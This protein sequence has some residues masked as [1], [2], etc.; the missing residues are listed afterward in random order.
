MTVLAVLTIKLCLLTNL[1]WTCA[2]P[3]DPE[4]SNPNQKLVER[5]KIYFPFEERYICY[6]KNEELASVEVSIL[7]YTIIA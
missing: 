4:S 6:G 5:S 3:L 7:I 1:M 2:I